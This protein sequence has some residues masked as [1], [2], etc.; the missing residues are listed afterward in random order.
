MTL[1]HHLCSLLGSLCP[2]PSLAVSAS[3]PASVSVSFLV[4]ARWEEG[5]QG[6][7]S[8]CRLTQAAGSEVEEGTEPGAPGHRATLEDTLRALTG[9]HD[10][11]HG[12]VGSGGHTLFNTQ[13][14]P[15]THRDAKHR[16]SC[17]KK[18]HVHTDKYSSRHTRIH[19]HR[20]MAFFPR[21][22]QGRGHTQGHK[23][24][25]TP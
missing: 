16:G 21:K 1:G 18:S 13:L 9:T 14:R 22:T 25:H 7:G 24:T 23:H 20:H 10:D 4:L 5:A 8:R 11:I 17:A 12:E 19:S 2:L 6:S 15:T 3:L